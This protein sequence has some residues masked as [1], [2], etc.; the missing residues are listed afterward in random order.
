[1]AR[2]NPDAD[3]S[4][5]YETMDRLRSDCLIG[6]GSL[7]SPGRQLWTAENFAELRRTYVQNLDEGEGKFFEKLKVQLTD[8]HRRRALPDSRT[9]LATLCVSTP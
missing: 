9:D 4:L 7:L 6:D 1:M 8:A 5:L 2:Y 3:L